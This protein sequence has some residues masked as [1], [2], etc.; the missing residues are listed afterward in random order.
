MGAFLF[1]CPNTSLQVQAWTDSDDTE[2]DGSYEMVTCAA[3][4][5]VHWVN[6]KTGKTIGKDDE[7]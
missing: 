7:D 5:E 1:R 2:T 6:P 4:R 3:C